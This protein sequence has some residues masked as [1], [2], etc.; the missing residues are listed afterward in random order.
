MHR[1]TDIHTDTQTHTQTYRHAH[2]HARTDRH[3]DTQTHRHTD[4]RTHAQRHTH[5][6][7][8]IQTARQ[9]HTHTHTRFRK[10]LRA[11]RR[12]ERRIPVCNLRFVCIRCGSA[13][14]KPTVMAHHTPVCSPS[15]PSSPPNQATLL[16]P[17]IRAQM[18]ATAQS[19]KARKKRTN[20]QTKR[21]TKE[22]RDKLQNKT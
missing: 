13:A 16:S 11:C 6:H 21:P 7:T 15:S 17:I 3:T 18:D 19:N 12:G 22:N 4:T 8:D 9:T 1:H 5:T 2:T 20:E 14:V 10:I